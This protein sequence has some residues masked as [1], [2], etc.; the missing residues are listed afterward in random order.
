MIIRKRA[1]FRSVVILLA[2]LWA[3]GH[4]Q[5]S[6]PPIFS[7]VS[8]AEQ[9]RI[10]PMIEAARTEG[11]LVIVGNTMSQS[12]ADKLAAEFKRLY[13]LGNL[14]FTFSH[15]KSPDLE[16][17]VDQELRAGKTRVDI[18]HIG[19]MEW[20]YSLMDSGELMYYDSPAYAD[21]GAAEAV[22]LVEPGY[23]AGDGYIFTIG[24]NR[25]LVQKEIT[26]WYD[27][28]DPQFKGRIAI[29]DVGTVSTYAI[30]Y[31]GLR[32]VLDREFFEGLAELEPK[33]VVSNDEIGQ[34]LVQGEAL[35]TTTVFSR[36][37]GSL[38][39]VGAPVEL[40]Y[41][42]EG[43]VIIPLPFVILAKA[44]HPNAAKLW[45]DFTHSE[46]AQQIMVAGDRFVSGRSNMQSAEP[47]LVPPLEELN[48]IPLDY[49]VDASADAVSVAR[50]EWREIF[51]K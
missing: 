6:A 12:T 51:A 45:I 39:D 17:R 3:F 37:V 1:T 41:P 16:T 27:L 20:L 23:W 24:V 36:V 18:T 38:Q 30:N 8:A 34:L 7:D 9:A 33:A 21:Y 14:K 26:S 10:A 11:E 46:A 28:L 35:V 48:V 50:N 22:N 4:A 49:R 43:I 31:I 2:G 5:N 47:D 13:G 42:T 25:A 32:K 40:V 19:A 44:L 15:I 29:G